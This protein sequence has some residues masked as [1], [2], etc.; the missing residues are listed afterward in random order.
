MSH[1]IL[2]FLCLLFSFASCCDC[3]SSEANAELQRVETDVRAKMIQGD[4]DAA[5]E[6]LRNLVHPSNEEWQPKGMTYNEWWTLRREEL[7]AE[8]ETLISSRP[9]VAPIDERPK[10]DHLPDDVL[11]NYA[12]LS[13]DGDMH[14]FN[15][16]LNQS[17]GKYEVKSTSTID[18][19]VFVEIFVVVD[20]YDEELEIR[21]KVMPDS[22]SRILKVKRTIAGGESA[23]EGLDDDT[24]LS[25]EH[26]G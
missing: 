23:V 8:L 4:Y 1:R 20:F 7:M 2:V 19:Q 3:D 5:L 12:A 9:E 21:S 6:L 14:L 13:D 22:P 18:G 16:Y 15:V 24:G 11:G 10:S 26:Q 17:T 25:F